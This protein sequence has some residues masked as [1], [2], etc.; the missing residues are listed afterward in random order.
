MAAICFLAVDSSVTINGKNVSNTNVFIFFFHGRTYD[1]LISTLI[2]IHDRKQVYNKMHGK[3]PTTSWNR[4]KS[5]VCAAA[6]C[7]LYIA[8]KN[9]GG[10]LHVSRFS[11]G[12]LLAC[13]SSPFVKVAFARNRRYGGSKSKAPQAKSLRVTWHKRVQGIS[14]MQGS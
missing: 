10:L 7:S 14:I 6:C 3:D 11:E 1:L 4:E 8:N 12:R 9:S 5:R 13:A 2:C